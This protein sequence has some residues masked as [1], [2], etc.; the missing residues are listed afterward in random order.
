M[1]LERQQSEEASH[2]HRYH[3]K[4]EVPLVVLPTS[5]GKPLIKL[6]RCLK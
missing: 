5:V 1:V 2:Q 4:G 6:V 3:P